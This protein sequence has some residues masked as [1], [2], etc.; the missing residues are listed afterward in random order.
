MKMND[1]QFIVKPKS[2]QRYFFL[3]EFKKK[4]ILN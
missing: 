4:E 1:V 3:T 2:S